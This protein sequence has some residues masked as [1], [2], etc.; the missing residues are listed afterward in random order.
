MYYNFLSNLTICVVVF[1]IIFKNNFSKL[2]D[3]SSMLIS[4]LFNYHQTQWTVAEIDLPTS[5]QTNSCAERSI[6]GLICQ[7]CE[8]LATCIRIRGQWQTLPVEMC[9]SSMGFYCNLEKQGCSN[10][11]S[12]CHPF[13]YEGNFACT[14]EGTFPD[15]Y[16]CQRYHMCYRAG[17]VLVSASVDCGRDKAFSA[18][19]GDCSL[20]LRDDVCQGK[21]YKCIHSGDS[22]H[23]HGNRNI[24][25]I[26]KVTLDLGERIMYPTLYRCAPGEVYN[27]RDCVERQGPPAIT[28]ISP[29]NGEQFKCTRRG[30]FSDFNDCRSY[31]YC[32]VLLRKKRYACPLGTHFNLSLQACSEGPCVLGI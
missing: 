4:F 16:D 32:D 31:F 8:L 21:Q 14:S 12:P 6:S 15:P 3:N 13:G 20:T 29:P 17:S 23:W 5:R 26:C 11:T 19:T 10:E 24:F 9:D 30:L 28:T 27:G 18:Q 2:L 25:Y 22:A 7:S 1:F